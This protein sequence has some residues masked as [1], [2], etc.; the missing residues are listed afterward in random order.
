M[1]D[2]LTLSVL[3]FAAAVL[4]SSVG[5][6]GASGYLAVMALLSVAP[7]AMKTP[8][9]GSLPIGGFSSYVLFLFGWVLFGITSLRA[10]IFPLALSAAIVVSA[11]IAWP[12]A[13]PPYGV[14][15]GLTIAGLGVWMLRTRSTAGANVEPATAVR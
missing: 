1:P 2:L 6:A 15:F 14:L 10:R 4:Y 3:I 11:L 9:I 5:H 12:S 8:N 13:L 7:E